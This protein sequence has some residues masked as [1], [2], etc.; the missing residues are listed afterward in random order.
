[1]E[2]QK[3]TIKTIDEDWWN[4][5]GTLHGGLF[6]GTVSRDF[7]AQTAYIIHLQIASLFMEKKDFASFCQLAEIFVYLSH[8]SQSGTALSE[9]GRCQGQR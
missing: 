5:L 6:K 4:V 3:K 9:T 2:C 7:P 1:M 8:S